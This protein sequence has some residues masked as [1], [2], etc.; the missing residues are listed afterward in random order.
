M[1]QRYYDPIAGRFLSIDPVAADAGSF[2][3]YWYANNNPYKNIDPDGR[4]SREFN[5]EN[6]MLGVAAPP[7]A[8]GDWM[9]PA[10]GGALGAVMTPAAVVGGYEVVMAALFNWSQITLQ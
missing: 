10:I 3:R 9:G 1:Q 2:N 6:R 5:W 7:R 4:E 8:E